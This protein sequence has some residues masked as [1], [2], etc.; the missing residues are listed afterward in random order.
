MQ[1]IKDLFRNILILGFIGIVLF[2]LFPDMMRQ[3]F[4]L[5]GQ[6]LGPLVIIILM[7]IALPT[8]RRRRS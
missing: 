3:V 8:K 6:L 1:F 5:Y 2:F 7:V 4:D